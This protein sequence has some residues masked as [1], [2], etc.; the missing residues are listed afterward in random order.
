MKQTIA[1]QLGVTEFPFEIKDKEG[2]LIYKEWEDGYWTKCLFNSKGLQI[3]YENKNNF[4]E[5]KEYDA[6][7]IKIYYEN[8]K[9][10]IE[11]N[12]P[13]RQAEPMTIEIDGKKYKLIEI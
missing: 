1:Q 9:G 4:W 2:N 5:K 11:D 10:E 13:K 8:S 12:R 7:G 6:Q 3:Y